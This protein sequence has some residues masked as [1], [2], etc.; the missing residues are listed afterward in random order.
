MHRVHIITAQLMF[1]WLHLLICFLLLFS[2]RNVLHVEDLMQMQVSA[3]KDV[4][5]KLK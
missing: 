3:A 2:F 4:V 1:F 5:L